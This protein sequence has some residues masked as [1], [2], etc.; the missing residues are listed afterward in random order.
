[1][2][3]R[4][5]YGGFSLLITLFFLAMIILLNILAGIMTT[6][7]GLK[8]DLTESGIYTLSDKA[9]DLLKSMNETVD[10]IV[11]TE[12]SRWLSNPTLVQIVD[13]LQ[14]YTTVSGGKIRVQYVDPALNTFE[15]P[16]FNNSLTVLKETY[17]ELESMAANDIVVLSSRRATK[18]AAS[19]LFSWDYDES[20]N[21]RITDVRADQELVSALMYVLSEE[22]ARAVFLEGHGES[23]TDVMQALFESCGYV[24]QT[25]NIA[26]GDIP[27]GT[28]VVISS[29]PGLDFLQDEIRKLENYLLTGGNVMIYYAFDAMEMPNLDGFLEQW[30]VTVELKLVCDEQYAFASQPNFVGAMV[31]SEGFASMDNPTANQKPTG[32]YN[33]RPIRS[34]WA[35]GARAGFTQ[36]PLVGTVSNSSYT[37]DFG[38]G[39]PTTLLRESGDESGPFNLTY[40][41]RL[42]TRDTDGKQVYSNLIVGNAG[43]VDDQVLYNFGAYFANLE[44]LAG[45]ASDLNPFGESVYIAPKSLAGTMM[46]VNAGQANTVLILIV[47]ALPLAIVAI[48]VV[49]WRRRRAL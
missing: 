30:G 6:R 20:Y 23:P 42:L 37:K 15:N 14:R 25:V 34:E 17:A 45:I 5:R 9:S 4:L 29:A 44:L 39:S 21:M 8:A 1:L 40:C 38:G 12:E 28:T 2:K 11:L 35:G 46:T 19:A 18:M 22:I 10:F 43:M 27:E 3:T 13:I 16:S 41:I 49:V 33:A 31:G 32:I 36:Y 47:I 26:T 48:G 24:C 7:F